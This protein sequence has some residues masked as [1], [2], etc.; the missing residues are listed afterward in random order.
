M[1]EYLNYDTASPYGAIL[2]APGGPYGGYNEFS[3]LFLG[4]GIESYAATPDGSAGTVESAM[5]AASAAAT[6]PI[7][8]LP[9]N[10]AVGQSALSAMP[11][12]GD[13]DP[14][15][16]DYIA[17]LGQLRQAAGETFTPQGVNFGYDAPDFSSSAG[18]ADPWGDWSGLSGFAGGFAVGERYG[19]R[20]IVGGGLTA[21]SFTHLRAHQT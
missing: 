2:T 3:M 7:T 15:S 14:D 1:S 17:Y 12:I 21:G 9:L 18:A 20:L 11:Y 10:P 19:D 4:F 16:F 13:P 8:T 6:E 5:A